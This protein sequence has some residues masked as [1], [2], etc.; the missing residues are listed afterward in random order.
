MGL[1]VLGRRGG[2]G[3]WY[4]RVE[5]SEV[6]RK[7]RIPGDGNSGKQTFAFLSRIFWY[8]FRD[9]FPLSH[10]SGSIWCLVGIFRNLVI[11]Q[12]L[13]ISLFEGSQI[14]AC[15]EISPIF[16]FWS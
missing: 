8:I 14:F 7:K 15:T 5:N 2:R 4:G 13:K 16:F 10:K 1:C 11:H 12:V 9:I 6:T 3:Q